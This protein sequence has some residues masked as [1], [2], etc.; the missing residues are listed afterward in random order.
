MCVGDETTVRLAGSAIGTA[1]QSRSGLCPCGETTDG[2]PVD[3]GP[4]EI[5][6]GVDQNAKPDAD[7]REGHRLG[8]SA[9]CWPCR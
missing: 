6:F 2:M 9:R 5:S 1:T 3:M 4:D 8:T 7:G